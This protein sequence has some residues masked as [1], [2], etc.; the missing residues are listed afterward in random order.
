M[1][2]DTDHAK[3]PEGNLPEV[4]AEVV[5]NPSDEA[6]VMEGDADATPDPEHDDNAAPKQSPKAKSRTVT[7]GVILFAI[8]TILAI[9][10]I[11]T[12]RFAPDTLTSFLS[13]SATQTQAESEKESVAEFAA[14]PT[15]STD[16]TAPVQSPTDTA[17]ADPEEN[18]QRQANGNDSKDAFEVETPL[19]IATDA[20][21][22]QGDE[23]DAAQLLES[24]VGDTI[25]D[26]EDLASED[27][28]TSEPLTA[29]EETSV[30]PVESA[31][32]AA[33]E[34]AV[35]EEQNEP[36]L[37]A[38]DPLIATEEV[39][40]NASIVV[41]PGGDTALSE[42]VDSLLA[43]KSELENEL[44][45]SLAENAAL[46]RQLDEVSAENERRLRAMRSELARL[47]EAALD[48]LTP[49]ANGAIAL[50][51]IET[52]IDA[53][54]PYESDLQIL[55]P[56]NPDAQAITILS[57]YAK[58]GAPSLQGVKNGFGPAARNALSVAGREQANGAIG[59]LS[60]RVQSLISV[61]PATPIAGDTPRAIISRAEAALEANDFDL[62]IAE[63]EALPPSAKTAMG[64]WLSDA[65]VR[66]QLNGALSRLSNQLA[67]R[68]AE[69]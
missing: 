28:E 46:R 6:M 51:A 55:A 35:I 44:A 26:L 21:V 42:Q 43:A 52:A 5:V 33:E 45:S 54:E 49:I 7:P 64:D 22:A 3:G 40:E 20:L 67:D 1:G 11:L 4:E 47:E 31:T 24:D 48:A 62:V 66:V 57:R 10:A 8:F 69:K 65:Y 36:E 61:R 30:P 25:A 59:R 18:L 41:E 34:L 17:E 38:S 13:G 15:V 32:V 68:A 16:F 53:G 56:L 63:L 23:P 14:Q 27:S 29:D 2:N 37:A 12:W 58:E 19:N 50:S 39:V 9:A 60:A